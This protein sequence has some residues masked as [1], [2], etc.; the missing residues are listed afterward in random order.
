MELVD[1]NTQDFQYLTLSQYNGEQKYVKARC[2]LR[3][4]EPFVTDVSN[5]FV[6]VE[7]FRLSCSP[8]EGGIYYRMIPNTYA[9]EV[10]RDAPGETE[11]TLPLQKTK[12]RGF[13]LDDAIVVGKKVCRFVP[14]KD[15]ITT[16]GA[17]VSMNKIF[18][19][20]MEDINGVSVTKG[21]VLTV[22][23]EEKQDSD[24]ITLQE[25]PMTNLQG[26]GMGE[27]GNL[28]V[29]LRFVST[30]SYIPG[31]RT[32]EGPI[33]QQPESLDPDNYIWAQ[34][35][36]LKADVPGAKLNDLLLFFSS[37]VNLYRDDFAT[38]SSKPYFTV[39]GPM[40]M[41][42][43]NNSMQTNTVL[44]AG[45]TRADFKTPL[46]QL[47]CKDSIFKK[48]GKVY[49]EHFHNNKWKTVS[50]TITY[51]PQWYEDK[52]DHYMF[53]LSGKA[54]AAAKTDMDRIASRTLTSNLS[55]PGPPPVV[56]GQE[57]PDLNL[58]NCYSQA[59]ADE[60]DL[61]NMIYAVT[62]I[63]TPAKINQITTQSTATYDRK[64]ISRESVTRRATLGDP[65]PVFTPLD[66]FERFNTGW[67]K[68]APIQ[69]MS[70][71][72]GGF[73][74]TCI[75][76][77]ITCLRVSQAML[78]DLGL[79]SYLTQEGVVSTD[80]SRHDYTAICLE[81]YVL[82]EDP[83]I[84]VYKWQEDYHTPSSIQSHVTM[85]QLYEFIVVNPFTREEIG[86]L[87]HDQDV[88]CTVIH[89]S[90][91]KYFKCVKIDYQTVHNQ[92]IS[93]QYYEGHSY[94]GDDGLDYLEWRSP[95]KGAF[96]GNENTVSIGSYS[97]FE[98]IRLVATGFG[99]TPFVV[100]G[101]QEPVL[102][103]L[104][105]PYS[106]QISLI[107]G[108]GENQLT[109]TDTTTALYGDL[110][111]NAP[112]SGH[113]Y[114]RLNSQQ[115]IYDMDVQVRLIPRSPYEPVQTVQLGYSDVFQVKLRFLLRN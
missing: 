5:A 6:A 52:G 34:I 3:K 103:E 99:F 23:F 20:M 108:Y 18:E 4:D 110:I 90:S 65:V 101:A 67:L 97:T 12:V 50:A 21:T 64:I 86:P 33:I 68:T 66:F 63:T 38:F 105:L 78:T 92:N 10:E 46:T 43:D 76:D 24:I 88:P 96:I 59:D 9:I 114:L 89:E 32:E 27:W 109:V 48:G 85:G 22:D 94:R 100:A 31:R 60:D 45:S 87:L 7:S 107:S 29:Y 8:N 84:P 71:P 30:A 15:K 54:T 2:V 16:V 17:T 62:E 61:Y 58:Y 75:E 83:Q 102:C 37:R 53:Y 19:H 35:K 14:D 70:D 112:P 36:I 55:E 41:E 57:L 42:T 106:N 79:S 98:N 77:S 40:F 51:L 95:K 73:R 39:F 26:P 1:V 72:N 81:V 113:Q 47:F 74:I 28:P 25:A 44:Y 13:Y 11:E 111:Y 80:P 115:A 69:L 82:T 56:N 49:T 91:G 104:R 93:K